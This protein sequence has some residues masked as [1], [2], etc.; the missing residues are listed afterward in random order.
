MSQFQK[1]GKNTILKIAYNLFKFD[2]I[3]LFQTDVLYLTTTT[4]KKKKKKKKKIFK[5]IFFHREN[6]S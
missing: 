5:K 4:T 3:F 1:Y 2:P 6:L